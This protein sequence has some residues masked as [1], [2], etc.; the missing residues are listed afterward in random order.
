VHQRRA[1][2]Q[3]DRRAAASASAGSASPQ[4]AATARHS[5][6]RMRAPP[7]TAPRGGSRRPGTDL[8]GIRPFS[9]LWRALGDH[10][11]D[12]RL[13]QLFG[14]YA[15]YC[16]SSPYQ[17]PATLMLV[18]HVEQSGVWLIEGGMHRLAGRARRGSARG[19]ACVTAT[20][21]DVA[22]S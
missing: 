20:A 10:F 8:L 21:T 17:A 13:R 12:P 7:G 18:A 2:Q 15:T 22:K 3:L 4:A 6:G 9:T 19:T 14:R 11:R 1:V 5:C 16:G